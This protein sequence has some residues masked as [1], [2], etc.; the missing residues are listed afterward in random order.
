MILI[1]QTFPTINQFNYFP[2]GAGVRNNN[3]NNNKREIKTEAQIQ[4]EYELGK[5]AR[6]KP[7]QTGPAGGLNV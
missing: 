6:W 3:N 1:P 7:K 5:R 4:I 2:L